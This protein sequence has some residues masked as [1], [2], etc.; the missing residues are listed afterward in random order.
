M[1]A[2]AGA[3]ALGLL[4]GG[5]SVEFGCSLLMGAFGAALMTAAI[6]LM[7]IAWSEDLLLIPA[8]IFALTVATTL[9]EPALDGN[10]S[11][12]VRKPM[13][14][15]TALCV[16]CLVVLLAGSNMQRFTER[17]FALTAALACGLSWGLST[18]CVPA[19]TAFFAR[20]TTRRKMHGHDFAE[21]IVRHQRITAT[22]AGVVGI[23]SALVL[24]QPGIQTWV[25]APRNNIAGT[26]RYEIERS[27][28]GTSSV[29]ATIRF[30][31]EMTQRLRFL[32][33]AAIVREV[34]AKMG[35]C[36]R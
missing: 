4:F 27:L 10:L 28:T 35:T 9:L 11:V 34:T 7:G 14:A 22:V 5:V 6:N 15:S 16:L 25:A 32:D 36:P 29:V 12:R 33:R 21:W 26:N 13:S 20:G 30:D 1:I 3:A 31:S 24:M 19:L 23:V 17:R 18:I 8:L 2:F